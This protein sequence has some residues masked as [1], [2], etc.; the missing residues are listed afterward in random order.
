MEA[1]IRVDT[2]KNALTYFD[3]VRS[4]KAEFIQI[5]STD[6][7][8]RYGQV[9][10]RKPGLLKWNYYP[11]TP[12]SIIIKGKTISYYDRELE[13]Y[14][15]TTINSPIINLLSSDMKNISTIDFVNIDTVN[16]QKIVTLYDKKSESQAE[17][18][19][20]INP[21]TIVGLNISNP[22]STTSIQFYNISSNIPIDKA[23]FKHDIS[24]Y[25][26]ELEHH[27]HHH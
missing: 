26:S 6:N 4:F 16:N 10:M 22:D 15:Y 12:V 27:H 5:S 18:I 23:E 17:V 9:L 8:P 24:H 20:N 1:D 7:I 3:A 11:P 2:I 25:Y 21:I 13:E 19:F 14:S